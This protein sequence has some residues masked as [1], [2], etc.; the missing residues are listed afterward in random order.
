MYNLSNDSK[1]MLN[2]LIK[3]AKTIL[4]KGEKKI[5]AQSENYIGTGYFA[6][7]K[8][9]IKKLD[10]VFVEKSEEVQ[11]L[12]YEKLVPNLNDDYQVVENI[13]IRKNYTQLLSKS[14]TTYLDTDYYMFFNKNINDLKLYIKTSVDA[15]ILANKKDEVLGIV[16]PVRF[17]NK[18]VLKGT[19]LIDSSLI[20]I[21]NTHVNIDVRF[22]DR[23][24]KDQLQDLGFKRFSHDRYI[25]IFSHDIL[26]KLG[27][28][29]SHEAFENDTTLEGMKEELKEKEI[30]KQIELD[31]INK[32]YKNLLPFYQNIINDLL[33]AGHKINGLNI[34]LSPK[35]TCYYFYIET[36]IKEYNLGFI[37][38][39]GNL[40]L[41]KTQQKKLFKMLNENLV[42]ENKMVEMRD[43][44][45]NNIFEEQKQKIDLLPHNMNT[46]QYIDFIKK[47][48]NVHDIS[49]FKKENKELLNYI[50]MHMLKFG[51]NSTWI[52][53]AVGMGF[54]SGTRE[55]ILSQLEENKNKN[56][57]INF[58]DLNST[59][60]KLIT[61][62]G[63]KAIIKH[64]LGNTIWKINTRDII[65]DF[66][67]KDVK[68]YIK[69]LKKFGYKEI[70][71]I[72]MYREGTLK[73]TNDINMNLQLLANKDLVN[74][75]NESFI[76]DISNFEDN[77]NKEL[78]Q[79]IQFAESL[80][81]KEYHKYRKIAMQDNY[82][83]DC[84]KCNFGFE[85]TN[86]IKFM[87]DEFLEN[88]N[89]IHFP[90]KLE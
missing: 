59:H 89:L 9:L 69:H 64:L 17:K 1:K 30:K 87:N 54:K 32:S 18:V 39:K 75:I 8:D 45:I 61:I 78:E 86:F 88:G 21:D 23:D 28:S 77:Y 72:S 82:L 71:D 38:N 74:T 56:D 29:I 48:F 67:H 83:F 44:E 42:L 63:N 65:K 49:K 19:G 46:R 52:K 31:M 24:I 66:K 90:Y 81:V 58:I 13:E 3:T 60:K 43:N 40:D 25:K 41:N 76:N 11:N 26:R 27:F 10:N 55:E 68:S 12:Q 22:L 4:N 50:R 14:V 37:C 15:V 57:T 7:K 2:K 35:K 73:K 33:A 6:V 62:E 53:T 79:Y 80:D 36:N 84:L 51:D 34:K 20:D 5:L 70:K 16:L 47:E 85:I